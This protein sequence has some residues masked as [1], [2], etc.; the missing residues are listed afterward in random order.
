MRQCNHIFHRVPQPIPILT[1]IFF[2]GVG[3]C[4]PWRQ[5]TSEG[6]DHPAVEA[7]VLAKGSVAWS[8]SSKCEYINTIKIPFFNI[9]FHPCCKLVCMPRFLT[10]FVNTSPSIRLETIIAIRQVYLNSL[11]LQLG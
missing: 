6:L 5:V 1:R 10:G 8:V 7:S 4:L 9:I 3:D 11:C 2:D